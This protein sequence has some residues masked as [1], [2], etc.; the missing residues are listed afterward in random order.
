MLQELQMHDRADLTR[1]A[2]IEGRG[3]KAALLEAGTIKLALN[4]RVGGV[5]DGP[6][7]AAYLMKLT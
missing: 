3:E 2:D 4:G 7:S 1:T 6:L 5:G